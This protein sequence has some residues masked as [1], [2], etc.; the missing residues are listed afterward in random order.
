MQLAL[1][2]ALTEMGRKEE[3]LEALLLA[4]KLDPDR[5][6]LR[7]RIGLA[8]EAIGRLAEARASYQLALDKAAG[9][10]PPAWLEDARTRNARLAKAL[11]QP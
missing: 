6:G 4:A 7:Y 5:P 9:A 1:G 11:G 2:A 10:E 8:Y 3:A